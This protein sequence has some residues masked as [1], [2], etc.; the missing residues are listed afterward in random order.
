MCIVVGLGLFLV[1]FECGVVDFLLH[2]GPMVYKKEDYYL[3]S[4]EWI[5]L[6]Y[7]IF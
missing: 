2:N 7:T 5:L 3:V 6:H 4:L 1:V